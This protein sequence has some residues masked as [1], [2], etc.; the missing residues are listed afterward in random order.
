MPSQLSLPPPCKHKVITSFLSLTAWH[1]IL[2]SL[3]P[4]SRTHSTD[5]VLVPCATA[6]AAQTA[7]PTAHMIADEMA[8]L[9]L[10][11]AVHTCYETTTHTAWLEHIQLHGIQQ[12]C[13]DCQIG[14][15]PVNNSSFSVGVAIQHLGS[16]TDRRESF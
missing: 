14:S 8:T 11:P 15:E 2:A 16:N 6:V 3:L 10:T 13:I 4:F 1:G 12:V 5:F 9:L 7:S